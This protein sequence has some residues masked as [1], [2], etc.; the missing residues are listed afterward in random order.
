MAGCEYNC[1]CGYKKYRLF[2]LDDAKVMKTVKAFF[3]TF[4]PLCKLLQ[5]RL[6]TATPPLLF[7][8]QGAIVIHIAKSYGC[9]KYPLQWRIVH[10]LSLSL[11]LKFL[12]CS[13]YTITIYVLS[14]KKTTFHNQEKALIV[15]VVS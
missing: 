10:S 15:S 9:Y 14:Q 2:S 1:L 13:L 6:N 4:I 11:V 5:K 3:I 7:V 12:A 8:N